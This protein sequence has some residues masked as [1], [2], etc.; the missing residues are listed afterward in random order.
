M[1]QKQKL[2]M[3][4]FISFHAIVKG[5]TFCSLTKKVYKVNFVLSKLVPKL[6]S[7]SKLS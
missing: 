3:V 5:V 1:K 6:N 7:G 2:V 4:E